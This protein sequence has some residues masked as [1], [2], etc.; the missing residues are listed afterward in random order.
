MP[1]ST[2]ASACCSSQSLVEFPS[3]TVIF[4]LCQFPSHIV[5]FNLKADFVNVVCYSRFRDRT[6]DLVLEVFVPTLLLLTC[7]AI[8]VRAA[9]WHR[10]K[11][12]HIG[13]L[14][15]RSGQTSCK[16]MTSTVAS[17]CSSMSRV[18]CL[19]SSGSAKQRAGGPTKP[20]L[21]LSSPRPTPRIRLRAEW[22]NQWTTTTVTV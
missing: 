4:N 21:R 14:A 18:R 11:P 5:I 19:G 8:L 2:C 3:R 22:P 17:G 6:Q 7:F 16:K 13:K 9:A 15:C 20:I 12:M 1:S 10:R